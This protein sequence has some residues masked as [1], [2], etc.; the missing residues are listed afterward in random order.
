MAEPELRK[1]LEYARP[2]REFSQAIQTSFRLIEAAMAA[3]ASL[4]NLQARADAAATQ[5]Q[6]L[7]ARKAMLA[8]EVSK[9]RDALLSPA[10][11][12]L[13]KLQEEAATVQKKAEADKAA[14]DEERGRRTTILRNLDEQATDARRKHADDLRGMTAAAEDEKARLRGEIEEL[15]AKRAVASEDLDTLRKEYRAVQEAAAKLVGR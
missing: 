13:L 8:D 12:S 2:V 7:E 15:K 3:E 5:T 4:S 10:R 11:A 1:L 9:E 14:F 6:A